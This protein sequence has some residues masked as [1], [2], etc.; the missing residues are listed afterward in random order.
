M[1]QKFL[2]CLTQPSRI[3]IYIFQK[4]RYSI[5][6]LL[7]LV[8]I[9]IIPYEILYISQSEYL[10]ESTV[11][12][13][14]RTFMNNGLD[15]DLA[16]KD[17]VLTGEDGVATGT[18]ELILFINPN[19]EENPYKEYS[20][21]IPLIEF[22]ET[23]VKG[24]ISDHVI[25]DYTY[26]DAGLTNFDFNEIMNIN[27]LKL[28]ELIEFVEKLNKAFIPYMITINT[29]GTIAQ[30][31]S[32]LILSAAVMA[33]IVKMFNPFLPYRL[34]F[35]LAL[36]CQVISTFGILLATL[37]NFY[38]LIMFGL[39]ISSMY[40]LRALRSIVRVEVKKVPKDGEE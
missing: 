39:F 13:I 6:F 33:L 7:A 4:I 36:D 38:H 9:A 35:K 31:F 30:M 25:F 21:G 40:L 20:N 1:F 17:G 26:L 11:D 28:N 5:I 32:L 8:V 23:N 16:I 29:I 3:G 2:I 27:Y 19:K 15:F 18:E 14:E 22:T 10:S 24:S 37:F 34:R 12:T